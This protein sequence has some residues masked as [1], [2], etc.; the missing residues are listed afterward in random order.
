M[1]V[2]WHD[3]KYSIHVFNENFLFSLQLAGTWQHQIGCRFILFNG[4]ILAVHFSSY[5][6][7]DLNSHLR[8]WKVDSWS[9]RR[10]LTK[11]LLLHARRG[12]IWVHHP[13][14]NRHDLVVTI[15]IQAFHLSR[16]LNM[17]SQIQRQWPNFVY[18]YVCSSTKYVFLDVSSNWTI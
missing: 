10:D 13:W 9:D 16:W 14:W 12:K 15:C 3:E 11:L 7:Q 1:H 6:D 2:T 5:N 8:I 18:L 4:S 17:K